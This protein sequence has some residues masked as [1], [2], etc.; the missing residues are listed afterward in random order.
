MPEKLHIIFVD[1]ELNILQGLRRQFRSQR[2]EWEMHFVD[3][4]A[5][6]MELLKTR[7]FDVIVSDMR[8]P[9]MD[10]AQLLSLIKQ[11]Y[12]HMV[13][14]VLSG[15]SDQNMTL[16]AAESAH[17]Y[18]SKPCD[19]EELQQ[20][21]LKSLAM[22]Q[23]IHSHEL[24]DLVAQV[25]ALP[26]PPA[27]YQELTELI[28][29]EYSNV[30]IISHTI[31]KDPAMTAKILQL[32]NSSFFGLRQR[33]T[34]VADAVKLLGR[35]LIHSIALSANLF[36]QLN[37]PHK[38]LTNLWEHSYEVACLARHIT[39]HQQLPKEMADAAFTAGLLHDTGKLVLST[40]MSDQYTKILDEVETTGNPDWQI[41]KE[42]FGFNHADIGG[43]L[44]KLWGLPD[45]VVSG[46][47][48]H[49]E[50]MASHE[51]QFTLLCAVHV[52][53]H[54]ISRQH[55]PGKPNMLDRE[56]ID[57]L[58]LNDSIANWEALVTKASAA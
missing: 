4:G 41:E 8:M 50:P 32:V 16:R 22:Q 24:I 40:R 27:L 47:V 56:Y 12:P 14:I 21:V 38:Q 52:A 6:T 3:S 35:A 42:A 18:L 54:L 57:H 49:H 55:N 45:H 5:A 20:T 13:R 25:D 28:E 30:Q 44:L 39:M 31:R 1:D 37:S 26:S 29:S 53:D 11:Q 2:H 36:R 19:A 7:H 48:F 43:Y 15:Y 34:N 46:V 33:V 17:R 23:S 51:N 58:G 10:G 9:E